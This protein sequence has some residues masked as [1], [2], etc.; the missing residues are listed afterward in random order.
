MKYFP[1]AEHG[2]VENVREILEYTN[3]DVNHMNKPGWTALLEAIIYG[4]GGPK[5]Q[6]AIHVLIEHGADV[7]LADAKGI[8]PLQHA[9][10]RGFQEISNIL[11]QAGAKQ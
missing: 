8:T 10:S 1:V 7:H 6:E 3:V 2:Y 11:I 5:Y 4:D 9:Q